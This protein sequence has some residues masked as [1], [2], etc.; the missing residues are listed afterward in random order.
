MNVSYYSYKAF[1][2]KISLIMCLT[3]G[4][5]IIAYIYGIG[6][7]L[8][9]HYVVLIREGMVK[10]LPGVRYHIV[11]IIKKTKFGFKSV[12]NYLFQLI[13]WRIIKLSTNII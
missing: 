9:K 3:S 11:I 2:H 13:A 7:S 10:N 4:F 8:Q 1:G 6:H 5:E 12:W